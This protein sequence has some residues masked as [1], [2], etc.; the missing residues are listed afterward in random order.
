MKAPTYLRTKDTV[1]IIS[2]ARKISMEEITPA[3]HLLNSWELTYKIGQSIGVEDHQYAGSD[4]ERAIDLQRMLDDP[5]VK[6]IWCARGGYGT[7]RILDLINFSKFLEQPKWIIGYSD[8]TVLHSH[9]QNFGVETLHATMPIN[10]GKN[11]KEAIQSLKKALFGREFK[12]EIPPSELNR[13]GTCEGVLVGG[14]LSI[15]YSLLGSPS[16]IDTKGKI[17]FIED[18][19][20]YL[21]H[22]DRM[23]MNLKRNGYLDQLAGLVVGGFTDMKDNTIP[24]GKNA[25]QIILDAVKEFGYPVCFNFPAGHLDDNRALRFG[26]KYM[27]KVK[28]N[29]VVLK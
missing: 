12:I 29:R 27:L 3:I 6:A 21:Y 19:D 1:G 23:M 15:L 16:A 28:E 2:T 24:F 14:N 17:L 11:T 7:V 8:I 22:T 9:L 5:E 13:P 26:K 20:E 4:K 25:H 10:V 18:L